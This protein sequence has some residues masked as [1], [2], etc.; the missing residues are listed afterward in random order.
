MPIQRCPNGSVKNKKT[1][2]CEPK[3]VRT[4]KNKQPITKGTDSKGT[5]AKGTGAKGTGSKEG[6]ECSICLEPLVKKTNDPSRKIFK[7]S[8]KHIFHMGCIKEQCET[9]KSC[10]LCRADITK[11]CQKKILQTFLTD[12]DIFQLIYGFTNVN[13]DTDEYKWLEEKLK[14]LKY[15]KNH[16]YLNK[17]SSKTLSSQ[18]SDM[19]IRY[20]RGENS[21]GKPFKK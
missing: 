20:E 14:S 11:D 5:D 7:T 8:C 1:G 16:V 13:E 19:L 17:G 3:K 18:A 15:D 21:F 9:N 10:P 12:E 4:V 6:E 2:L